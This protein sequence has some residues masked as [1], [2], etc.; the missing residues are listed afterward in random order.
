MAGSPVGADAPSYRHADVGRF[1]ADTA[2][3]D[4]GVDEDDVADAVDAGEPP[5]QARMP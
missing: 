2:D 1:A 5:D 3:P 4:N